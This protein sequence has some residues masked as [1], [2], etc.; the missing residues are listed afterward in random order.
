MRSKLNAG[1]HCAHLDARPLGLDGR[2]HL[3]RKT[4]DARNG[5]TCI[6][7]LRLKDVF[8]GDNK[9]YL[10][11][12]FCDFDLKKYM[13]ANG[14]KLPTVEVKVIR[15]R[16]TGCVALC[17]WHHHGLLT[18]YILGSVCAAPPR[19]GGAVV[20]V[21]DHARA[22]MVPLAPYISSVSPQPEPRWL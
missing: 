19:V 2:G 3:L 13:K 21:S 17:T 5:T 11:F 20:H 18:T 14:N 7:A 6:R 16:A 4:A 1:V 12:E 10:S 8:Y 9:L 15:M 22:G